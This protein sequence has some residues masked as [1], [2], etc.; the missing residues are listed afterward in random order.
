VCAAQP[1][2]NLLRQA[3]GQLAGLL[4]LKAAGARNS[5]AYPMLDLACAAA[6]EASD[7]F[8]GISAPVPPR[9]ARYHRHVTSASRSLTEALASAKQDLHRVD[10]HALDR[11]LVP[12]WRA[13]RELQR[14]ALSLPGFEI[15]ALS[16]GCCVDH[17]RS[18][19]PRI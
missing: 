12:L 14:A 7:A 5:A 8:L 19:A 9:A 3:A 17:A 15:V 16:Q 10:D 4:V 18:N 6:A 2:F 13:Y 11:I 1:A